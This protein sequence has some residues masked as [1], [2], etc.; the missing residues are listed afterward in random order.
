[1][2]EKISE[3]IVDPV[4]TDD[5]LLTYV[6]NGQNFSIKQSD[7]VAQL[8][9]TGSLEQDGALT[10]TPV[11]EIDGTTNK[12]RNIEASVGLFSQ[13]SP[14]NGIKLITKLLPSTGGVQ[15]LFNETTAPQFRSILAGS[16]ISVSQSGENILISESGIPVSTKTIP[17]NQLS[18]FPAAVSGVITLAADTEYFL[19]GD[20]TT[21]DRFVMQSNTVL[22]GPDILI[23]M[24]AY[25]GTGDM[26]TAVDATCK[27]KDIQ[28]QFLTAN[29]CFNV[30]NSAGNEGTDS[31]I[32]DRIATAGT[33]LGTLTS[34]ANMQILQSSLSFISVDGFTY[35]GTGWNTLLFSDFTATLSAGT[36]ID[37]GSAVFERVS[38]RQYSADIASGTTFLSGLAGS[39]NINANGAGSLFLGRFD[40]PGTILSGITVDD[41]RWDYLLNDDL[42]DTRTEGLLSMQANLTPTVIISTGVGELVAGTWVVEST[43]RM[44]GTTAGRVTYDGARDDRLPITSSVTV[45]PVSGGTQLMGACIAIN[46]VVIPN[47][48]RTGA[49]APNGPTSLTIPWQETF[50]TTDFVEVFVSNESGTTNV[51]ASSAIHRIN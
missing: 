45:E 34:L 6:K 49:A 18:D 12:I 23:G 8:G 44:T 42:P 29:Q 46:G 36:L 27:V 30:S 43:S 39:G 16:G 22:S 32:L 41:A 21:S 4:V 37:L 48:L 13:V 19:T 38:I 40:G 11:L 10:G 7:Y 3:F 1:M 15:T 24:L 31:L 50:S 25:T 28:L 2:S 35:A 33:K 14:E 17:I 9:V 26:F 51:L 20:I 47:S 5:G